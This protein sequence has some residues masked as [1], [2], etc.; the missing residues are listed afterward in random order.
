MNT[1]MAND[2]NKLVNKL[3]K[4]ILHETG[5]SAVTNIALE[6]RHHVR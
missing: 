1:D 5:S 3:K 6:R 4:K 2:L